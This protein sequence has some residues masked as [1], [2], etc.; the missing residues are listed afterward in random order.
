MGVDI[1]AE[2]TLKLVLED[3]YEEKK[4]MFLD[5][6]KSYYQD[7]YTLHQ[8]DTT[9]PY[10]GIVD[11]LKKLKR[12]GVKI[13]VLSNKPHFDVLKILD[14]YF[15]DVCFDYAL[16]K[17]PENQIKPSIDGI[18]E[19]EKALGIFEKED[20]LYVGDTNVDMQTARNAGLKMC[21]CLWGF[22]KLE[23]LKDADRL[24]YVA[25]DF[26]DEALNG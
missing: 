2:R 1:L 12:N 17:K 11:A 6:F 25:S 4:G 15:P 3:K 22:R 19:I 8:K 5:S 18:I 13:A 7:Y 21:A 26:V 23:E 20:I 24:A 10:P 9:A 16:G 14:Y